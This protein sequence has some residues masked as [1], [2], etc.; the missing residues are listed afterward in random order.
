MQQIVIPFT[1]FDSGFLRFLDQRKIQFSQRFVLIPNILI[2]A[3]K[4]SSHA[5]CWKFI[6]VLSKKT[7]VIQRNQTSANIFIP[8]QQF[9]FRLC[10][11]MVSLSWY[12]KTEYEPAVNLC[13]G[14]SMRSSRLVIMIMKFGYYYSQ[15]L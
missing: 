6:R 7:K 11:L 10:L 5:R 1:Q 15:T 13:W 2:P 14:S 3:R 8:Y 12:E 9:W 4:I